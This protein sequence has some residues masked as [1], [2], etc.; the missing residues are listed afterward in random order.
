[1]SK[2]I[3]KGEQ[4][5]LSDILDKCLKEVQAEKMGPAPAAVIPAPTVYNPNAPTF[6][7]IEYFKALVAGKQL[8][9]DQR[10]RLLE[11]LPLATKRSVTDSIQWLTGLP[12]TPRVF[13]P[14][15]AQTPYVGPRPVTPK[16]DQGYYA[17]VDP[18]DQV[19]KFYQVRVPKQG[20]WVG[21]VFVS[22]VSGEN[23]FSIR[24]KQEREKILG[25]ILK[26]PVE[27]LKRFGKEIGQ[28]GHC[29]KQL[30]DA[31]SRAFG[32]GPVCRKAL[33]L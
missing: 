17:I 15:P 10:K 8:T 32:I 19:L 24:D 16:I 4:D 11:S 28:C 2:K 18:A 27:A 6:K 25:E 31:E 29:R 23:H 20:R 33:G 1:M 12:W 13:V 14:R 3:H 7:Q 30:T 26:N 9:D 22:Q 21:Y 5:M